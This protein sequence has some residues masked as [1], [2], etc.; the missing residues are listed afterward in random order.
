MPWT[1]RGGEGETSD[2]GRR[3][4]FCF[5]KSPI[6]KHGSFI[7]FWGGASVLVVVFFLLKV[8]QCFLSGFLNVLFLFSSLLGYRYDL[9]GLLLLVFLEVFDSVYYGF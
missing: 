9:S 2:E 8:F 4:F 3:V 1:T 7:F 5:L 6:G